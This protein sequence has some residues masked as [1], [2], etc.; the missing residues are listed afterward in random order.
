MMYCVKNGRTGAVAG[1]AEFLRALLFLFFFML[2]MPGYALCAGGS[3]FDRESVTEVMVGV[4]PWLESRGITMEL[5]YIGES[6]SNISGGGKITDSTIYFANPGWHLFPLR[7][8]DNID[9]KLSVDTGRAGMW[10]DGRFFFYG[11]SNTG[12][13]PTEYVGGIQR[14]SNIEAPN[15]ARVFELWYE[16]A[17]LYDNLTVLA[18]VHDLSSEFYV[19]EY[20]RLFLNRSFEIGP[21][22]SLNVPVSIF[23]IAGAG[24]RVKL[25]RSRRVTILA[26][27]YDGD[28]GTPDENPDGMNIVIDRAREG[29]MS[30]VELQMGYSPDD[31][32]YPNQIKM[33]AWYHSGRFEDVRSRNGL[34]ASKYHTGN[35]GLYMTADRTLRITASGRLLGVFMQAGFVPPEMQ[36]RNEVFF[37]LGG[38]MDLPGFFIGRPDDHL[39]LAVAFAKISM[40]TGKAES[41]AGGVLRTYEMA[42]E[43]TY[44]ARVLKWLTIQPDYQLVINPAGRPDLAPANY[45]ALRFEAVF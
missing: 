27:V 20:G 4:K 7:Y 39:G 10:D 25:K 40:E 18:G 45:L 33:G 30:I 43:I 3:V 17:F 26:G 24:A 6:F 21:E 15:Q 16:H 14:T 34:E 38:G 19:S 41:D 32:Y 13:D 36:N 9:L 8:Q 44:R 29:L 31:G 37:Y 42:L 22:I 5:L 2:G 1:P 23:N 28:P 12:D 11:L 35:A